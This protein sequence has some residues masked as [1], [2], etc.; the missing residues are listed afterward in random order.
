MHMVSKI[1]KSFGYKTLKIWLGVFQSNLKK[2][3]VNFCLTE[4]ISLLKFDRKFDRW[5]ER[6][7]WKLGKLVENFLKIWRKLIINLTGGL[8]PSITILLLHKDERSHPLPDLGNSHCI[9]SP[10]RSMA[11]IFASSFYGEILLLSE[12]NEGCQFW[13]R[14]RINQPLH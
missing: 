8:I 5:P 10:N 2:L 3:V 7:F 11:L 13:I 12:E 4:K 6:F 1:A 14:S 9:F